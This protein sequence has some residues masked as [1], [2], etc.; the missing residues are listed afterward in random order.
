MTLHDAAQVRRRFLM[1]SATRWLPTGLTIPVLIVLLQE[2][3]LSL[4]TIGLLS[5]LGSA[6]VALLELPTGGLADALGRRPVLL[7]AGLFSLVSLAISSF[8]HSVAFFALAWVIE[9]IYRALD[10]G[11]LESWYV[12]SALAADPDADIETTLSAQSTVLSI[13]IAGGA[14]VGGGLALIP[15]PALP[16]L[17]LPILVATVLRVVDL[18]A[19]WRL[20]DERRPPA[21]A[22]DRTEIALSG[23]QNPDEPGQTDGSAVRKLHSRGSSGRGRIRA[24]VRAVGSSGRTVRE[25]TAL[26]RTSH[27]LLA[28]VV[29]ECLWGAGM[30]GVEILSGPRMVE[31]LGDTDHG[32]AAYAL[33]A[34]VAWSISGA[35]AAAAPWVARRTGS[36][37]NAAI[38][39]RIAQGL[40]VLL[41]VVIAGPVGLVLGYSGFYLVHGAANVAHYGLVHRHVGP[42]HRSTMVSLN[43]LTSRVGGVI[44]AP[45]LGAL[46]AGQGLP[47]AFALAAVLLVLPAPLYLLARPLRASG[48]PYEA[49]GKGVE[50]PEVAGHVTHAAATGGGAP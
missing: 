14:L 35:G 47:A 48:P 21:A 29:I 34:A 46:A 1:L 12:D 33:T 5:G 10:S 36:W 8:A 4:A 17:A 22:P 30:T 38:V 7:V 27:A 11:P 28:L 23:N 2:R 24:A 32:V 39:A 49:H 15:A 45:V 26:L 25:A 31:L 44:A 41:A 18:A 3:G 42:E 50:P 16:A 6:V 9:G 20:L 40:G 13:A 19:M 37:V 43:S